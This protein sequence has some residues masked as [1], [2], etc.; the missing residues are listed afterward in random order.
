MLTP[1][2]CIRL[3]SN[4]PNRE[5]EGTSEYSPAT[6][7]LVE[8]RSRY[9]NQHLEFVQ[10]PTETPD[11]PTQVYATQFVDTEGN[12]TAAFM[13]GTQLADIAV[14]EGPVVSGRSIFFLRGRHYD[15]G[16]QALQLYEYRQ[17]RKLK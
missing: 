2:G 5:L 16:A 6:G 9:L 8:D 13:P 3:C 14:C 12:R 17:R 7:D 15:C 4:C 10:D 1:E 11:V